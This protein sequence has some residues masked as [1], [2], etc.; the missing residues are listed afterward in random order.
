MD[1]D[2]LLA[3]LSPM[4]KAMAPAD[5]EAKIE[6]AAKEAGADTTTVTDDGGKEGGAD[7]PFGKSF[8]VTLE[9]G[10]VEEA[11]DATEMLKSMSTRLEAAEA[12]STQYGTDLDVAREDLTKSLTVTSQLFD[13][14]KAQDGLIKSLRADVARIGAQPT[15]RRTAVTIA[16]RS[17]AVVVNDKPSNEQVMAKAMSLVGGGGLSSSDIATVEMSL[18]RG[19]PLPPHIAEALSSAA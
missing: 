8:P 12:A 19:M 1:F 3:E 9:D 4:H 13:I 10:R 7:E 5:G 2:K 16:E 6:A 15:G 17:P 14:V 11:F 18:Q